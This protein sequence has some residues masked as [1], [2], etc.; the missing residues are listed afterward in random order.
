[1]APH[2]YPPPPPSP[3]LPVLA[4]HPSNSFHAR[5]S[6]K[7]ED[8]SSVPLL[9]PGSKREVAV[10]H[11]LHRVLGAALHALHCFYSYNLML[12]AMTYNIGVVVAICCGFGLGFYLHVYGRSHH[13][14][15][16][17]H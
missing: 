6:E 4:L 2:P 17:C 13:S 10:K 14:H 7:S 3:S 5:Q 9:L 15:T 16:M 1:M 8:E 11:S 12:L